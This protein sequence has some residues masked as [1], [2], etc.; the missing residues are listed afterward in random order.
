[1]STPPRDHRGP[2]EDLEWARRLPARA[3]SPG[4]S[5]RLHGYD[6]YGDLAQHYRFAEL[7]LTGL[8]GEAPSRAEG[9][10]IEAVMTFLAPCTVA[11]PPSHIAVLSRACG[12]R[13]SS[14]IA[15]SAV[16]L[17]EQA[18]A[19]VGEHLPLLEWLA[20]PRGAPPEPFRCR[21]PEQRIAV[22]KL[23]EHVRRTATS[24]RIELLEHDPTL[25]AALLAVAYR[26]GLRD[27]DHLQAL[28][29]TARLPVVLAEGFAYP[30]GNRRDYPLD[31]PSFRY[32]PGEPE[33][34]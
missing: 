6:V 13:A 15:A 29:V 17:A 32:S 21:D 5:P 23:R 27:P 9:E 19:I 24:V 28:I 7:V 20:E 16:A 10:L 26:A 8:R 3:I 33:V 11:E 34:P 31:L 30:R 4:P 22:D 2:I 1:M 25:L 18:A 12:A 14:I